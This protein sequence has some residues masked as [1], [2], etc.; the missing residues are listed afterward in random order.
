MKSLEIEIREIQ[1]DEPPEVDL[2]KA[3]FSKL[4][5]IYLLGKH[6]LLCG[7]STKIMEGYEKIIHK[8]INKEL[9]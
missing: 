5:D 7:D 8:D 4:G 9:F 6:R 3:P 1:E 2:E